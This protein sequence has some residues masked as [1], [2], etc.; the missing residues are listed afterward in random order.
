MTFHNNFNS[1]KIFEK[2]GKKLSDNIS[3]DVIENVEIWN[4]FL[5]ILTFNFF[6]FYFSSKSIYRYEFKY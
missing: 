4:V 2:S 6:Y 1:F 5:L 3:Y